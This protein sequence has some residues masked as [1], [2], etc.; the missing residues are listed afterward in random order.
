MS[1]K[2]RTSL[3]QLKWF[4]NA[5][6]NCLQTVF[7]DLQRINF[8]SPRV[9]WLGVFVAPLIATIPI[10]TLL[11]IAPVSR[12]IDHLKISFQWGWASTAVVFLL[13]LLPSYA[14]LIAIGKSWPQR[15]LYTVSFSLLLIFY[16]PLLRY[17]MLFTG[18]YLFH[19]CL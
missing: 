14:L 1:L 9:L 6:R 5:V 15:L 4:A 13:A 12:F 16:I 8:R 2:N 17:Y 11:L 3:S 10:Q 18:C 7:D 19:R